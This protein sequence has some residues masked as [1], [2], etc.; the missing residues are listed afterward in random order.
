MLLKYHFLL[1][2]SRATCRNDWFQDWHRKLMRLA[3]TLARLRVT[4]KDAG[5]VRR[6]LLL[7]K[8]GNI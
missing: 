6:K 1:K 5:P 2:G 8:V 7:A 3:K 4:T